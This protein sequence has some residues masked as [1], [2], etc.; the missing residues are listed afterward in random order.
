MF[1]IPCGNWKT[2]FLWK[3]VV[4]LRFFSTDILFF[5]F[6]ASLERAP[7]FTLSPQQQLN[8]NTKV[9]KW[10]SS[11][12]YLLHFL[13]AFNFW[14]PSI[15]YFV[16]WSFHIFNWEWNVLK[17]LKTI[18]VVCFYSTILMFLQIVFPKWE[19]YHGARGT[20]KNDGSNYKTERTDRE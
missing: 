16:L 6:Q 15:Q 9:P 8:A 20:Y 4:N 5:F 12:S 7:H 14:I 10:N 11:I 1:F 3:F 17:K 18:F 13:T 19:Q 2:L